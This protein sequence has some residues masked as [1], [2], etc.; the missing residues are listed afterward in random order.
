MNWG[1]RWSRMTGPAGASAD[2]TIA[3]AARPSRAANSVV[4][5][6]PATPAQRRL[7]GAALGTAVAWSYRRHGIFLG[8][9][10]YEDTRTSGMLAIR[11]P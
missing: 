11:M 9:I 4:G 8:E 6:V 2:S 5:S 1:P 7:L 3:A 10:S